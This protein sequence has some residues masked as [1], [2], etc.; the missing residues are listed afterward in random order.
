[1]LLYMIIPIN[2]V[3]IHIKIQ[4]YKVWESQRYC[5]EQTIVIGNIQIQQQLHLLVKN[6]FWL[7]IR[8]CGKN[9]LTKRVGGTI[10][11]LLNLGQS[12]EK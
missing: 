11:H 3:N 8:M 2:M 12:L 1:M 4:K 9:I 10:R 7:K 6:V 5:L